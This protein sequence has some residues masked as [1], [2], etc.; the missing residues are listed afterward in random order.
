MVGCLVKGALAVFDLEGRP[1]GGTY[2]KRVGPVKPPAGGAAA[3]CIWAA[4]CVGL[5]MSWRLKMHG[6]AG[7]L[8]CTV[9]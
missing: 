5:A 7:R 3:G 1:R 9:V 2:V 8:V 4:R 6:G